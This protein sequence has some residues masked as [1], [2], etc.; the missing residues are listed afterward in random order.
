MTRLAIP[1]IALT[2]LASPAAAAEIQIAVQNPVVELSA[3]ETVTSKPDIAT[4]SSGVTTEAQTAVEAMRLNADAMDAVI[5]RIK[6]LGIDAD[7][8]QTTGINLGARY[9]YDQQ[10]QRQVFRGYQA[11]NRVSVTLRNVARAGEVLDALVAA[12]ATDV[13]GPDFSLADDSAQRAQARKAAFDH[14]KAQATQYAVWSGYTGVQLL[15]VDESVSQTAPPPPFPPT[16]RMQAAEAKATPVEPGLVTT[17]A[18]LTVKFEMT[19]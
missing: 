16:V 4:V 12:G 11:S 9:D 15:E 17:Q 18:N 3:S 10:A 6:A 1:L 2:A 7:D 19:R 13:G 5:K 8:I 14:A